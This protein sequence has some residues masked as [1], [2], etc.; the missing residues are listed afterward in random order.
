M[1]KAL[2]TPCLIHFWGWK[3]SLFPLLALLG[4]KNWP[5]IIN[6][7]KLEKF[8]KVRGAKGCKRSSLKAKG[9]ENPLSHPF[10]KLDEFPFP[11][12]GPLGWVWM[13]WPLIPINTCLS[14]FP[15]S[16]A[17]SHRSIN[18]VI[19]V[20]PS[21]LGQKLIDN[22]WAF[23]F[24]FPHLIPVWARASPRPSTRPFASTLFFWPQESSLRVQRVL[25]SPYRTVDSYSTV[26]PIGSK[27]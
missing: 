26:R 12:I 22:W 3:N 25:P 2:K 14:S 18:A 7:K 19:C 9:I 11:N 20:W 5:P 6:L 13:P 23:F 27:A 21:F 8:Q 4:N 24:G 17:T 15:I 1:P 10:F 16:V